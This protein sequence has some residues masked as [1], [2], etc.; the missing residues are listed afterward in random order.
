MKF[1]L[2]FHF[3]T[4]N[5]LIPKNS[6]CKKTTNLRIVYTTF[7]DRCYFYIPVLTVR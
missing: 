2:V 1:S 7:G 3:L 5:K 6:K 4:G